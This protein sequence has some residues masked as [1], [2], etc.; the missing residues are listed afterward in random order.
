[1]VYECCRRYFTSRAIGLQSWRPNAMHK[2]ISTNELQENCKIYVIGDVHGCLDEL[3]ELVVKCNFEPNID[4]LIFVG[5][6]VNKGPYSSEVV[7]YVRSIGA[8]CVMGNHDEALLEKISQGEPF[9]A[10][11]SYANDLSRYLSYYIS[12]TIWIY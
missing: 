1:M 7:K 5:D 2:V 11:Y 10:K 3:K 12:F 4:K 8:Y 9:P 6:L